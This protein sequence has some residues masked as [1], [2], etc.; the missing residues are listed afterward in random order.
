ME[1][2][3][4]RKSAAEVGADLRKPAAEEDKALSPKTVLVL[5]EASRDGRRKYAGNFPFTVPNMGHRVDVGRLRTQFLQ[6]VA[7]VEGEAQSISEALA[8]LNVTLDHDG[9]PQWWRDCKLG[10]ELY[11]YPPLLSLYAQARAYEATF[12]GATIKPVDDESPDAGGSPTDGGG[13]V[14]PD[15]QSSPERSQTLASFGPGSHG[16]PR[17]VPGSQESGSG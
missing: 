17:T 7:N 13:D 9:C 1:Q 15:V 11:D 8:Y 16:T 12:L 4:S 2:P 5:D 3:A 10:I 14:E 6:E